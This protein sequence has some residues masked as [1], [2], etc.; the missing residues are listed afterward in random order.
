MVALREEIA[1]A[2]EPPEGYQ[3]APFGAAFTP[4]MLMLDYRQGE[5]WQNGRIT[6]RAPLPL[7]P[8]TAVLH[9]SQSVFEG[10]KAHRLVD[11]GLALF[12]VGDHARRF[13]RSAERLAMPVMPPEMFVDLVTRFVRHQA[14]CIPAEPDRSL[15]LRPLMIAL[16]PVLGVRPSETYLFLIIAS[17]VGTYFRTSAP[18]VKLLV[19][20]KLSRTGPG[21]TGAAK[22]GGNYAASLLAQQQAHERGCDQ[23]LWLDACQ[24]RYVEEMGGMNIFFYDRGG[25]VTPPLSD[26]ILAGVTRDSI[27]QLARA[28]GIPVREEPIVLDEV[29]ARIRD[30]SVTEA[31]ACGTAAVIVPVSEFHYAGEVWCLPAEAPVATRLREQLV[32]IHQGRAEDPYHW[33]TPV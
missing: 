16:D 23:V 20:E 30:G 14:A 26:T 32:A 11:G 3:T 5:G 1:P 2:C 31:F 24:R 21:G 6:A 22:T 12:R 8:A 29:L 10:L 4:A 25:L 27:L 15:Y 28:C 7:D 19:S 17:V 13:A 33:R 9:Y 18:S